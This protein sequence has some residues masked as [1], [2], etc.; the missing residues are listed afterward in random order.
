MCACRGRF[1]S[2]AQCR[3]SCSWTCS[4]RSMMRPRKVWRRTISSSGRDR[5]VVLGLARDPIVDA[6]RGKR[7]TGADLAASVGVQHLDGRA[8]EQLTLKLS[9]R[10]INPADFAWPDAQLC[11]VQ[12]ESLRVVERDRESTEGIA[13]GLVRGTI[14]RDVD[15]DP[16]GGEG[17]YRNHAESGGCQRI[18]ILARADTGACGATRRR[19]QKKHRRDRNHH[20]DKDRTSSRHL[21]LLNW[22]GNSAGV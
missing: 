7:G 9:R 15:F 5:N 17:S 10:K 12:H 18:I 20:H 16:L 1:P 6:R 21:A 22:T 19:P 8:E 14:V 4:M 11:R 13:D 3:S 2:A